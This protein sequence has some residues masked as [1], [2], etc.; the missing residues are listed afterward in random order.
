MKTVEKIDIAVEQLQ[1]ALKAYFDGRY[2][3]AMVLA[4]AAEQLFAGYL[5]KHRITPTWQQTRNAAAKIARALSPGSTRSLA[6][7]ERSIGDLMNFAYNN[8]KHAGSSDH[9]VAIEP[10]DEAKAVIDRAVSDFDALFVF[11]GYNLP[12]IPLAQKFVAESAREI[13]SGDA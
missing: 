11:P 2:F 7:T 5:H 10:K 1:D 6:A 13:A 9:T 3:S 12:D 4:G 8:A